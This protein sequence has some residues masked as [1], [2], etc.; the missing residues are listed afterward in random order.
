MRLPLRCLDQR[1]GQDLLRFRPCFSKPRYKY[2]VT[3]R[4][5]MLLCQGSSTLTGVLSQVAGAVSGASRLLSSGP[6]SA[7]QVGST[8]FS[9]FAREMVPLVKAGHSRR[10]AKR[11]KR[12]GCPKATV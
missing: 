1:F 9:Y 3:I 2:C 4:P 11:P 6:W 5:G 7:E 10:R 8:W 12:K